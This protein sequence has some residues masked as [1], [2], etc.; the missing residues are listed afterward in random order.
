MYIVSNVIKPAIKCKIL[1][2]IEC[3]RVFWVNQVYNMDG[4]PDMI[5]WLTGICVYYSVTCTAISQTWLTDL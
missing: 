4:Q 3:L 1:L 2:Q 5:D